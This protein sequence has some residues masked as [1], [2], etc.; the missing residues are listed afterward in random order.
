MNQNQYTTFLIS[1]KWYW[2]PPAITG[3][4]A[5]QNKSHLNPR[6]PPKP[7]APEQSTPQTTRREVDIGEIQIQGCESQRRSEGRVSE[8]EMKMKK[9]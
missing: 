5:G 1:H 3:A 8:T 9:R 4:A 7:E 6:D 2:P